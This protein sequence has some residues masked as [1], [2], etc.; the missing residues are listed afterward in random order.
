MPILANKIYSGTIH[1]VRFEKIE[2]QDGGV[3]RFLKVR[4]Q[5]VGEGFIDHSLF[6]TPNAI[7]QTKKVLG[8][9]NAEIWE[10]TYPFLLRDP[11]KYLK[12]VP[13]KIETE[14]DT[15]TNSRGIEESSV[16][17]KWL[18]GVPQGV[19]AGDDDIANTLAMMGIDDTYVA[20]A[21]EPEA[22]SAV[23]DEPF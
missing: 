9:L 16:R 12:G 8:E 19:A 2:K 6:F 15:Y 13:C 1:R 3:T 21:A 5:V 17:V 18:N 22:A 23:S 4:V 7:A 14:W 20:P 11:E 10:G